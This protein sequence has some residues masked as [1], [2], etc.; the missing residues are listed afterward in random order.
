MDLQS[1]QLTSLE[2]PELKALPAYEKILESYGLSVL[3]IDEG[4]NI[5]SASLRIAEG[6]GYEQAAFLRKRIFEID[7]HLSVISWKKLWDELTGEGQIALETSYMTADEMLLPVRVRG[8][9]VDSGQQAYCLAS[10][11]NLMDATR[12]KD[13]LKAATRV[14]KVGAWEWNLINDKLLVSEELYALLGL[15][16]QEKK[17]SD[18]TFIQRFSKKALH[19]SDYK[20]LKQLVLRAIRQGQAFE[21]ELALQL[22]PGKHRRVVLRAIP[23]QSELQ[24]I[25]IYGTLQDISSLAAR[26][27]DLHLTQFTL[28]HAHEMI[29]WEKADGSLSYAN[30]T[31]AEKLG[32]TKDELLGLSAKDIV[33]EYSKEKSAATWGILRREGEAELE[34]TLKTKDG[35]LIPIYCSMNYIQFQGQEINC[36]FARDWRKK[37]EQEKKLSDAL[38]KIRE[39]SERLQEENTLLKEEI[40]L[41]YN[42][43]NI[44]SQSRDYKKILQ[45]VE[46]VA[47][48]DATVLIVGETGTGKELLARAIHQLS[49][50]DDNPL[51]KVNCAGLPKDLI[52]SELFGHEKGAFT[53]AYQQKKGRFELAHKGTIFLD[54]IG[55][56][57]VALQAKLL[58]VLQ[59][60]EFERVGGNKTIHV[61]ARVIAAT[62]RN[63]EQMVDSGEFREDLFYRLNVFPIRNI[64]LRERR[65]DIP[66]LVQHFV[67]K[68]SE[69]TGKTIEKAP[70]SGIEKLLKYEFPGNIRELENIVE[71]AVILSNG[72]T[73]NLAASLPQTRRGKIKEDGF[74]KSFEEMQREHIINALERTNW[75]VTGPKGAARLLKM[76]G[77]TL[78]SKMRRLGIR[79]E[80][81]L[82]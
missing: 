59:E 71:R 8:I 57:P 23:V 19:P 80:D 51:I 64:P 40:N 43:N 10:V 62:N 72:K 63:L 45:Q 67:K 50:R 39:L 49:K 75:R 21:K 52:E 12:Y 6:L 81:F 48:T 82:H 36:V 54:E 24:A 78:A 58:R 22:S 68:Y 60:G 11:E 13:L 69:K 4:G 47:G 18:K 5:H 25:R 76:N 53:G 29:F 16:A 1:Q 37:K 65:E 61:D 15:N 14:S 33:H 42:F 44:I 17:L 32:Y 3:L 41:N 7:P 20:E 9:R 26:H 31:A 2:A 74:F 35:A 30:I 70:K 46:Q 38:E 66:L 79:R 34:S 56:L 73:L 77:R 27:E 28:D 55:E